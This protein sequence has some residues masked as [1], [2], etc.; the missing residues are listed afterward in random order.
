MWVDLDA[1]SRAEAKTLLGWKRTREE[2][3]ALAVELRARGRLISAIADHVRVGDRYTTERQLASRRKPAVS[4]G[5]SS[6]R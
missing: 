3:I 2:T 4:S 5:L 1:A 6:G